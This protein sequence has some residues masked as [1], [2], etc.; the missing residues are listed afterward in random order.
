MSGENGHAAGNYIQAATDNQVAVSGMGCHW[1]TPVV[2][3]LE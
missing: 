2:L 1:G 3:E